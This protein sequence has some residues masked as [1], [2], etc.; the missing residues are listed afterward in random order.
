MSGTSVHAQLGGGIVFDPSNFARNV[1]HYARRLEQM[2]L[3]RQQLEQQL[4]AMRKLPNPPMRDISQTVG[5]LNALMADGRALSYQ[6][7]NLDQQ[8]HATFPVDQSYRDWPTDRRAQAQ[9]TVATMSAVLAGARAQAQVFNEGLGRI[10][11]IKSQVGSIQGHEA[12][13]ELQNTAT[14]F[15]AEELMLLRQALMAQTSMQ[16]V[17]YADRVNSEA[18]QAATID[19]HLSGLTA[20]A[21]RGRPISLRVDRP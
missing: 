2:D 18:Q 21:R 12:A 6:L 9:R 7:A 3:Q 5:Q 16:A 15:S 10:A 14:V 20:P 11:Q 8:F 13:L 4:V 17:Y 1:L 19:E